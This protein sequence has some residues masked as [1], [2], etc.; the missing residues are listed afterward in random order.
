MRACLLAILGL[1]VAVTPS[2]SQQSQVAPADK[3]KSGTSSKRLVFEV[4]E[5]DWGVGGTNQLVYIRMFSDGSVEYH[6][7]RSQELRRDRVSH[8]EISEDQLNMTAKVLAREDVAKLPPVFKSTFTP[9][10]FYWTLDLGIPRGAQVQRIKVVNF[11]P[12]MAVQ[13]NK[14]YPE[15]LVRLVCAAWAD[16]T[17]LAA[18]TPD[19]SEDCRRFLEQN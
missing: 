18:E 9:I 5:T 14:T 17:R 15:A 12:A 13:N 1:L 7:K 6:P 4:L 10:D 8:G 16:R 19:L 2:C 11:S 3:R